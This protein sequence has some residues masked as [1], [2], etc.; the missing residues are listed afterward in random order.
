MEVNLKSLVD[1]TR[2]YIRVF[3]FKD[4]LII[5]EAKDGTAFYKFVKQYGDLLVMEQRVNQSTL[6]IYL[7]NIK[8]EL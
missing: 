1:I 5:D 6:D 8:E 4:E 3:S 2:S 7:W